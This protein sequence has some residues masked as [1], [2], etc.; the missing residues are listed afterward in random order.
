METFLKFQGYNSYNFILLNQKH[1]EI[2]ERLFQN[3]V[4]ISCKKNYPMDCLFT[5]FTWIYLDLVGFN[6]ITYRFIWI[7]MD[8]RGKNI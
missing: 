1:V 4:V 5:G 2:F 3:E 8:L 6:E 7:F